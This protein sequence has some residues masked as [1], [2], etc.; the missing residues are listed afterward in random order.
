M[1]TKSELIAEFIDA[2]CEL[3]KAN[4]LTGIWDNRRFQTCKQPVEC[5]NLDYLYKT[6]KLSR[7]NVELRA[8]YR[9]RLDEVYEQLLSLI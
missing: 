5:V 8:R 4:T 2:F 7:Q 3:N 9:K 1:T 6:E